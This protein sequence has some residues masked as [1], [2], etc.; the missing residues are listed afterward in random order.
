MSKGKAASG[1][2]TMSFTVVPTARGLRVLMKSPPREMFTAQSV[3]NPSTVRYAT[4]SSCWRRSDCRSDWNLSCC[5]AIRVC[6]PKTRAAPAC[7][8][9][10]RAAAHQTQIAGRRGSAVME[11]RRRSGSG[12][13]LVPGVVQGPVELG[14]GEVG[15]NASDGQRLPDGRDVPDEGLAVARHPVHVEREGV[16]DPS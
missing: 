5:S 14:V 12:E 2:D 9:T 8:A 10:P 1:R 11:R 6:S 3:M 7:G 4:S 13:K 16:A 15:A